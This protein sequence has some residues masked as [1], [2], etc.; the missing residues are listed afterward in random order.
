[1][2]FKKHEE[3]I[4]Q[5]VSDNKNFYG[6]DLVSYMGSYNVSISAA[7]TGHIPMS[8]ISSSQKEKDLLSTKDPWK[9]EKALL[10]KD[11]Q[12]KRLPVTLFFNQLKR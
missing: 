4:C 5:L 8:I 10:E 7:L 3:L 6:E 1:M 9:K 12:S 2:A 11:N